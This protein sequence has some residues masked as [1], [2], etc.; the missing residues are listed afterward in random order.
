MTWRAWHASCGPTGSWSTAGFRTRQ[1]GIPE[2]VDEF[3]AIL[4]DA[5]TGLGFEFLPFAGMDSIAADAGVRAPG[6]RSRRACRAY[7]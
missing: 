7:R 2:L 6:P 5:G 4:T 1:P 3:A